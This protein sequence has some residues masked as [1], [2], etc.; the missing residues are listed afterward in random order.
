MKRIH[1]IKDKLLF[2]T[3]KHTDLKGHTQEWT[4]SDINAMV[5]NF[6]E[7]GADYQPRAGVV[8]DAEEG[9]LKGGHNNT[10][11]DK[12]DVPAAGKIQ[13][14]WSNP[15]PDGSGRLALYG[16][17]KDV[18]EGIY[19]IY[20]GGGFPAVSPEISRD[21]MGRGATLRAVALQGM[22]PPALKGQSNLD[23]YSSLYSEDEDS[24]IYTFNEHMEGSMT[25]EEAEALFKRLFGEAV[26]GMK[27]DL[28]DAMTKKF[29][30]LTKPPEAPV[31]DTALK[32]ENDKLKE[33]IDSDQKRARGENIKA[34]N[35]ALDATAK[36]IK[37][38]PVI[39]EKIKAF[40]KALVEP[41][42][43]TCSF[44]EG[45][46]LD[47]PAAF[48]ELVKDLTGK[49]AVINFSETPDDPDAAKSKAQKDYEEGANF[50]N[51]KK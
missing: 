41:D 28:V 19:N 44:A 29:G 47:I 17:I 23:V 20:N 34:F 2:W 32:A 1:G 18:P 10:L 26:V 46:P 13:K 5:S 43:K 33:Q 37:L 49:G 40:N 15:L 42:V 7:L 38:K 4:D 14:L 24:H 39:T 31:P 35:E 21:F 11:V 51:E 30:E 48:A 16:D 3:G 6:N 12:L 8:F 45:S 50:F 25:K 22:V 9:A 36:T 27:T